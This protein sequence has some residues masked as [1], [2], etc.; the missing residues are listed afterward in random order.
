MSDC[1]FPFDIEDITSTLEDE[2]TEIVSQFDNIYK[3]CICL[4]ENIHDK[5]IAHHTFKGSE[6]ISDPLFVNQNL[7]IDC[8]KLKFH[9]TNVLVLY[10]IHLSHLKNGL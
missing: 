5:N 8:K 4:Q 1:S 9:H 2:L 10:L 3:I 6:R 7:D